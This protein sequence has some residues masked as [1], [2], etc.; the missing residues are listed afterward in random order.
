MSDKTGNNDLEKLLRNIQE[1]LKRYTLE[2]LNEAMVTVLNNKHDK[3]EETNFVLD[4]VCEMYSISRRTLVYSVAR[5]QIKVARRLASCLLYYNVGLSHR[6]I[7][8]RVFFCKYH[9]GISSGIRA[10]ENLNDKVKA[11]REFKG[12]Y[13]QVQHQLL[14]F[15]NKKNADAK[16][17][18]S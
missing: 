6:F 7:A 13:E 11:D 8:A 17:K 15:L 16:N 14:E 12:R 2:E 4:K 3:H 9:N 10:F 5:G 1:G 18:N